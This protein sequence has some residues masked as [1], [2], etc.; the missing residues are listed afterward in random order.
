MW[1][2]PG[3]PF[4]NRPAGGGGVPA[5]SLQ[6][7][8]DLV[9]LYEKGLWSTQRYAD[10]AAVAGTES[11]LYTTQK[12][13]VGQGFGAALSIAETNMRESGRIQQN[14]AF[15]VYAISALVYYLDN[16]GVVY[17]DLANI[18]HHSTLIWDFSTTTLEIAPLHLIGAGGGPMGATA[19]TGGAEGTPGSRIVLNNGNGNVWLYQEIPIILNAGTTFALV[20]QWGSSAAVIDGGTLNS[21]LA[22]KTTLLGRFQSA[23]TSG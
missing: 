17:A 1:G 8:Q 20:H 19:D 4:I 18:L 7:Q 11:R 15:D 22:L 5:A 9:R 13:Q 2:M 3:T 10:A 16:S 23:I 21:A 6:P 14:E 12:G